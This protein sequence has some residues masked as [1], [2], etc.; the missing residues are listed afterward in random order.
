MRVLLLYDTFSPIPASAMIRSQTK[1]MFLKVL[2]LMLESNIWSKRVPTSSSTRYNG[3]Y[4]NK[5]RFLGYAKPKPLK[6]N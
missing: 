3:R 2:I 4:C 6:P 1:V 5:T